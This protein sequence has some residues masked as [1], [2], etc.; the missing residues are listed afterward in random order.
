LKV[1]RRPFLCTLFSYLCLSMRFFKMG[2][3]KTTFSV[4]S[5][6]L[7]A[8]VW[9]SLKLEVQRRPFPVLTSILFAWVFV[10]LIGNT[11]TIFSCTH[12]ISLCLGQFLKNGKYRDDLFLYFL[13]F[14]LPES[15][16]LLNSKYKD[17]LF[18]YSLQSSLP[19]SAFLQN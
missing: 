9:V 10:P 13:Q 16:F 14:S 19:E 6:I 11:K 8:W 17:D 3:T 1:Q 12:F 5:S 7:F 18:L 4:L 2:S 15:L